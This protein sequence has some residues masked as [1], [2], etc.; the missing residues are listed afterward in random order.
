MEQT[1]IFVNSLQKHADA[2]HLNFDAVKT[3]FSKT[4]LAAEM[5]CNLLDQ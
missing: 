2:M 1:D 4:H 5:S 3:K